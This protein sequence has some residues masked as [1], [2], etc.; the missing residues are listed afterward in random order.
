MIREAW[1][2]EF[3]GLVQSHSLVE[4]SDTT[5]L[6]QC[7]L[8]RPL[9]LAKTSQR[10]RK[11]W[12]RPC[13]IDDRAWKIPLTCSQQLRWRE[14][15]VSMNIYFGREIERSPYEEKWSDGMVVLLQHRE[16]GYQSWGCHCWLVAVNE[17][18]RKILW[19][20][21]RWPRPDGPSGI[22]SAEDIW[23]GRCTRKLG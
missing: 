22:R 2:V 4:D 20:P 16:T 7:S 18:R 3:L 23:V 12:N 6:W 11:R 13:R 15:N 5:T 10:K 9:P 8:F 17:N 21:T 1:P 14:E 19:R